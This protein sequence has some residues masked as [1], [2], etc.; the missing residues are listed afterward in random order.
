MRFERV[1]AFHQHI[2]TPITDADDERL[3]LE[4]GWR[5]PRAKDLENSL[6]CIFVLDGRALRTFVSG[7]HV[8]HKL[9]SSFIRVRVAD[10][11]VGKVYAWRYTRVEQ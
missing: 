3:D 11:V 10:L 7:D 6:L 4:T 8:L 1:I 9:T 5:L 2:P